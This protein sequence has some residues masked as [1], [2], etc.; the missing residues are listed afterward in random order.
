M[1]RLDDDERRARL[2]RRQF[3]AEDLSQGILAVAGGL[4]GLHASDPATVFLSL[5][6]RCPAITVGDIETALYDDRSLLKVLA[7]RRTMFVVPLDLVPVL[8]AACTDAIAAQQRR[9]LVTELSK[10]E[11]GDTAESWV[12]G[13]LAD[14]LAALEARGPATGTQVSTDVPALRR[15]LTY[16][17]GRSWGGSTSIT[18]RVLT[19]LSAEGHIVRGRPRGSLVSSQYEWVATDRW[20]AAPPEPWPADE[21]RVELVRRWLHTFGPATEADVTWWTGWT[22]R[23]TRR[24][25]AGL[26]LVAVALDGDGDGGDAPGLLLADDAEPVTAPAPWVALLPALDPTPMGWAG[27]DWYLGPHRPRLFDRNGNVGPTVWCDGRVVGGW[28]QRPDG[29]VVVHLLND[30]GTEAAAAIDREAAQTQAWLGQVRV[31]GR[32]PTPLERELMA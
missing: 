14:T 32:F 19:I 26:D 20:L 29:E 24:A 12:D 7:M 1:R 15:Q 27:R 30:V 3:L 4:V 17:E 16:G 9:R 11:L 23:D 13:V 10:S 2:G 21:A 18:T 6:A 28:A 22:K 5:R 25:L 8:Q 31:K